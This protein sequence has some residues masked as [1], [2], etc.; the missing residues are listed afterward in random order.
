M[1][2]I[3]SLQRTL[4]LEDAVVDCC[5]SG[6]ITCVNDLAIEKNYEG[7]NLKDFFQRRTDEN[8]VTFFV[9]MLGIKTFFLTHFLL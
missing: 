6:F 4:Q 9:A 5:V 3:C 7:G 8:K 2:A 1:F